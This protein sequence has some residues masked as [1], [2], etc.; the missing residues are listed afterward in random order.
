MIL[1]CTCTGSYTG[2]STYFNHI[3]FDTSYMS[4]SRLCVHVLSVNSCVWGLKWT[5]TGLS[6]TLLLDSWDKCASRWWCLVFTTQSNQFCSKLVNNT[7]FN[8][9]KQK[10]FATFILCGGAMHM[11]CLCMKCYICFIK[12]QHCKLNIWTILGFLWTSCKQL[13]YYAIF[14]FF[15]EEKVK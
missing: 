7:S 1:F 15:C 13:K 8:Q 5:T 14:F 12:T 6:E 2:F 9:N 11:I 10:T 3:L 4:S